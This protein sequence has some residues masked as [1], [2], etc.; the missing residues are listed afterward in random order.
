MASDR[1]LQA[2]KQALAALLPPPKLRLSEWLES[3]L[4]LP[5]GVSATPGA[6]RLWPPQRDIAD[7]IGDPTIER[8]T[9]VKPVRVGF[10]TLLTGVIG[11]FVANEPSPVLVLLPTEADARDYMVSDIEPIFDATP[12]LQGLLTAEADEGGRNT[13]LHRRFAGGSLKIVAAKAPR[14]LRRHNVRILLVDEADAM[15]PGPEGSPLVLAERRTLS[16]ANRKIIIGST[17]V[18]EST[19]AVLQA[20]A[21]SDM[22]VFE[23]PCPGCGNFTEVQWAHIEWEEGK[24]E[25]AAFRCPTCEEIVHER[26]KA[27]MV[28]QG[29]WRATAPQVKGHAG[30]RLNAL[31][32]G[33]S[34][35]SWGKL[36]AEFIGAKSD[37]ALLQVFVNT[38]LAQGWRDSAD[39]LNEIDLQSRAEEFDLNKIPEQVIAV[40]AGVDVQD[41]RLEISIVG[42]SRMGEIY[43]LGHEVIFGSP[44]DDST[45]LELEESLRTRWSH[46]WGGKL[47]IDAAVI[48]SGDGDWADKV[49]SFCAPRL[50]R[51]IMAGK[52]MSGRRPAIQSSKSKT[53]GTYLFLIG[54]DGIKTTIFDRLARGKMIRFSQS[55]QPVYYEQL[56]SERRVLRYVSGKPVRRFERKPGA[57][58]ETLDCLVYAYAARQGVQINFDQREDTLRGHEAA[59]PVKP[60]V[61]KSDWMRR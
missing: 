61:I 20:Y 51:R 28:R 12:T 5:E 29:A 59:G 52:G 10:T 24:P 56:T 22:R 34:N 60:A 58:A 48:D 33:L 49:Y 2:R 15:E 47:K 38:I 30:F 45:W 25:T 53:K 23:V 41:D 35:A 37:P 36:A 7:A 43:V 26:F 57:R 50:H 27:Q 8:V 44:D 16:F 14:N 18:H 4:R 21:Q 54:V 42:W 11:S 39:D 9:I 31:V 13:L 3:S 19:S 46:P 55:L 17:P 40:T 32:S 1:L 6:M